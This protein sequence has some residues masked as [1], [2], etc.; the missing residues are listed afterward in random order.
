VIII[1]SSLAFANMLVSE[2]FSSEEE[3]SSMQEVCAT[4]LEKMKRKQK[5]IDYSLYK[6]RFFVGGE[7]YLYR[8]QLSSE[9]ELDPEELKNNGCQ[10]HEMLDEDE[11]KVASSDR[12]NADSS[13]QGKNRNTA[14][15]EGA[16]I[17]EDVDLSAQRDQGAGA[18]DELNKEQPK[19]I[20]RL[21]TRSEEEAE[22]LKKE[23]TPQPIEVLKKSREQHERFAT[24]WKESTTERLTY[25]RI[26]YDPMESEP[27]IVEHH[28]WRQGNAMRLEVNIQQGEGVNSTTILNPEGK[29]WVHTKDV[30][31]ATEEQFTEQLLQRFSLEGILSILLHFPDDLLSTS[32][33]R[34][35][36]NI[37]QLEDEWVLTPLS[38]KDR[39]QRVKI[40]VQSELVHSVVIKD[41]ETEAEIEYR[42]LDYRF[43]EEQGFAPWRIEVFH[44]GY[45]YEVLILSE[46]E[47]NQELK[48]DFFEPS[49]K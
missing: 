44:N 22:P 30:Y 27:L 11:I 23:W 37:E 4:H 7:G 1:L 6:T 29:G 43:N 9:Q 32:P 31:D 39:I 12:M 13:Q 5:S 49:Q 28:F 19:L 17:N 15:E 8:L 18:Q 20:Q 45:P 41:E 25:E 48:S 24:L 26:L 33:W 47:L 2:M 35:L 34:L 3:L 38:Q 10:L 14:Q 21:F 36:E 42:F 40:G 16:T 46:L